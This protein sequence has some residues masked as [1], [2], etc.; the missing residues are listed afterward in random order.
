M[1]H[2]RNNI[3]DGLKALALLGVF[4]V[5]GLGY[6]LAPYYPLQ[7]GAPVPVDSVIAQAIHALALTF[8][9][10]KALPF[11]AFLFGYS[12]ANLS[13]R[14]AYPNAIQ[15]R[16]Y[17]L[18]LVG[19][20]HG[21]LLYFGDILTAYALL[22]LWCSGAIALRGRSLLKRWR[23]WALF[24]T[25]LILGWLLWEWMNYQPIAGFN[26]EQ[27]D[28]TF[29]A[30][31]GY[32]Q[33]ISLNASTYCVAILGWLFFSAPLHICLFLTGI[34]AARYQWLTLHPRLPRLFLRPWL[35]R[36]WP[37]ALAA[38]ALLGVVS[39]YLHYRYGLMAN[40]YWIAILNV[41]LGLWMVA[42]C[43]TR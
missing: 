10:G 15:R 29:G 13:K 38:N 28:E 12:M 3:A 33:F 17:K 37:L 7:L 34:M 19:V 22:G 30:A 2:T 8:L 1:Q 24:S 35:Y 40:I 27:W 4:I 14:T 25:A 41:P 43:L 5:N 23:W 39:A 42:S 36:S 9:M 21:A 18:L 6:A 31:L 16:Q 11:L 20:L 26:A 32:D